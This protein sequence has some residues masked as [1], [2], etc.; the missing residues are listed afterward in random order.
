MDENDNV[1]HINSK[2]MQDAIS[3]NF[4]NGALMN[5]LPPQFGAAVS[6]Q[7]TES[8]L[9]KHTPEQFLTALENRLLTTV[10][11]SAFKALKDII[12]DNK[13]S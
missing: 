11:T 12:N 10:A 5:M 2:K 3:N 4:T 9:L 1:T 13:P 8:V 7:Y 6:G